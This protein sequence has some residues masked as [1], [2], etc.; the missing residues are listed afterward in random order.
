M[1][2]KKRPLLTQSELKR[3]FSYNKDTGEFKRINRKGG[4][5]S[6]DHYG[7]LILKIKGYQYKAHR[8]AWLYTYGENPK[9]VI[10]HKNGIKLD[11]RIDNLRDV[12]PAVNVRN[13]RRLPNPKTGHIGI[14]YDSITKGL[15]KNFTFKAEGK[16]YRFKTLNEA[17]EVKK[18]LTKNIEGY[19]NDFI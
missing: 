5:G 1:E 12:L 3:H 4:N 13:T 7:Y 6:V 18:E 14:Y 15:K 2:K 19:V 9:R 11:N 16:T 10:D 17:I 8:M